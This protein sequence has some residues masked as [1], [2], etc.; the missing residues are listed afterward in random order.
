MINSD[1]LLEFVSCAACGPDN[2][3]AM[4]FCGS[5]AAEEVEP[6]SPG[7]APLLVLP[8]AALERVGGFVPMEACAGSLVLHTPSNGSLVYVSHEWAA[9]DAPDP[10][11][12]KFALLR[13][14][15]ARAAAPADRGSPVKRGAHASFASRLREC[16]RDPRG[17][18]LWCD[19]WCVPRA[20]R[21]PRNPEKRRRFRTLEASLSVGF[22]A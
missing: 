6:A 14:A 20:D 2:S 5:G 4:P 13:A 17:C 18:F 1:A 8:V 19:A 21:C 10:T 7:G 15:L 11:G 22:Q 12:A 3:A 16:A 9:D